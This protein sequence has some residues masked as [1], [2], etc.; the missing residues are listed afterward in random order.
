MSAGRPNRIRARVIH[1]LLIIVIGWPLGFAIGAEDN[2]RQLMRR[3][4][5][6]PGIAEHSAMMHEAT[7]NALNPTT[8][9]GD[10]SVPIAFTKIVEIGDPAAGLPDGMIL[11]DIGFHILLE[12]ISDPADLELPAS[13]DRNGTVAFLGYP[14][15]PGFPNDDA[16]CTPV[17]LYNHVNGENIFLTQNEGPA[18]GTDDPFTG[19]TG[20]PR[21]DDGRTI[22]FAGIGD[23]KFS[24]TLGLWSFGPSVQELEFLQDSNVPGMSPA[25]I[26]DTPFSFQS[27]DNLTVFL[28]GIDD[29]TIDDIRPQGLWQRRNGVTTPIALAGNPAPGFGEGIVYGETDGNFF[30]GTIGTFDITP[31]GRIVYTAFFE[32]PGITRLTD[33]AIWLADGDTTEVL[34]REGDP[35]PAG[36]F[37]PGSTFGSPSITEAAFFGV[38]FTPISINRNGVVIFE[39]RVEVPGDP[40]RVP[41]LW[42]W[43][44]GEREMLIRGR[45]RG[46]AFSEPGDPA[47]GIL[48]GNFFAFTFA[49]HNDRGDIHIRAF[50]ETNDNIFDSTFGIWADR[51]QG[52]EPVAFEEGPVPEMPGVNFLPEINNVR[53]IGLSILEVDGSILYTGRFID[54]DGNVAIGLFRNNPDG[55]SNFLFKTRE[56]VD[57]SGDGTDLRQIARFN[58]GFGTTDDGRKVVEFVFVDGSQGMYT[59]DALFTA[60]GPRV[61]HALT[62][63]FSGYIDPRA[64][65]T[66]GRTMDLGI[67]RVSIVFDQS[68][69]GRGGALLDA[70]AFTV[71]QTGE[72]QPPNVT[73]VITHDQRFINLELDRPLTVGEWTTIVA[74][75]ENFQGIPIASIGD[76]GSEDNEPDRIDIGYLPGDVDQSGLVSPLDLLAW[77]QQLNDIAVPEQG[78]SLDYLDT[79]RDGAV[80][81]LDLNLFR[82]L[83]NGISPASQTW[84]GATLNSERP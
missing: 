35:T 83:I 32:G 62:T 27:T 21:I 80:T 54:S 53:G 66:D 57:V 17:A 60:G 12:S 8:A 23:N 68:V 39:A 30:I 77:R 29:P 16:F 18:P 76:L 51:G 67:N 59:F 46:V 43:E 64:E 10:A 3:S 73:S 48:G 49:D 22:F 26:L 1:P 20:T 50:V 84:A 5:R 37:S 40:P 58:P 52:I 4:N 70:S 47:P 6:V 25:G 14:I 15:V 31:D 13:I 45:E 82:R 28:G 81:P 72:E 75:V 69:Q 63:P 55:T 34:V 19:I 41:S 9:A 44:N 11:E 79:D 33:E 71:R 61:D 7:S 78:T 56:F 36:L 65:S 38:G 42:K 2:Q 24:A 74:D